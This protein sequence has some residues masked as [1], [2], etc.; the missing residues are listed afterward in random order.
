MGGLCAEGHEF[1][2]ICN[3]RNP[4]AAQHLVDV[5]VTQHS[6]W[7][8]RRIHRALF[9]QSLINFSGTEWTPTSDPCPTDRISFRGK[10]NAKK[11]ATSLSFNRLSR[12]VSEESAYEAQSSQDRARSAAAFKRDDSSQKKIEDPER[13]STRTPKTAIVEKPNAKFSN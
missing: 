9:G 13:K 12:Q 2:R 1:L 5:L 6:R 7:S 10:G 11:R 8:A 3:K 4:L